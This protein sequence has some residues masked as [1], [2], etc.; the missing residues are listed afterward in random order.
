M[1]EYCEKRVPLLERGSKKVVIEVDTISSI[2]AK[3]EFSERKAF[4]MKMM[5]R[6]QN[7]KWHM[8]WNSISACPMCGRDLK[9]GA[10]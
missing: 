8:E 5:W 7:G 4:V 10:E 2:N 6:T 3:G 1:C 9:G